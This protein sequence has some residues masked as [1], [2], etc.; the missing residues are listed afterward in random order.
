MVLING[1]LIMEDLTQMEMRLGDHICKLIKQIY[2]PNDPWQ[3]VYR[4]IG[5]K[6]SIF[7]KILRT[8]YPEVTEVIELLKKIQGVDK[9]YVEDVFSFEGRVNQ[10]SS[11][12][13]DNPAK[14]GVKVTWVPISIERV[15]MI[16]AIR[17][18]TVNDAVIDVKQFA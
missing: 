18:I 17:Q 14:Y 2:Y 9:Q 7:K 12:V 3:Q 5:N 15:E 10:E 6:F 4:V 16:D 11:V 8:F 1:D 13:A